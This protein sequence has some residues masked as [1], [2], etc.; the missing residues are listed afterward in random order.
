MWAAPIHDYTFHNMFLK[1]YFFTCF[2]NWGTSFVVFY[3]TIYC[4]YVNC[5]LLVG[6]SLSDKCNYAL[7]YPQFK[8]TFFFFTVFN[9]YYTCFRFVNTVICR[10]IYTATLCN[11]SLFTFF[12]SFGFRHSDNQIV[13]FGSWIVNVEWWVNEINNRFLKWTVASADDKFSRK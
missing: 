2:T 4:F 10:T 3:L 1:S 7:C 12:L 11:V 6:L 13:L 9:F 5:L 8:F